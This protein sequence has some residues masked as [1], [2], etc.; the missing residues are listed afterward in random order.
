MKSRL[1]LALSLLLAQSVSG[2]TYQVYSPKFSHMAGTYSHG[3]SLELKTE[4]PSNRIFYTLNQATPDST[5]NLYTAPIPLDGDGQ[6]F[7]I[8][9]IAIDSLKKYSQVTSSYYEIDY[10][11]DSTSF[12]TGLS[13]EDYQTMLTGHWIGHSVTPWE[14]PYNIDLV[15]D[16]N[17]HFI[18][19]TLSTNVF[20]SGVEVFMPP[21]YYDTNM[22][23][24]GRIIAVK[25]ISSEGNGY[26]TIVI[27]QYDWSSWEAEMRSIRFSNHGQVLTL[28]MWNFDH[29]PLMFYLTRI[30][31]LSAEIAELGKDHLISIFPNP[32]KDIIHLNLQNPG[33][34][35]SIGIF[36]LDGINMKL[37][38]ASVKT[39]AIAVT[40]LAPGMY[41]LKVTFTDGH[42]S[43]SKFIKTADIR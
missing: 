5:S 19:Q 37:D 34:V 8:S 27:G 11:C 26:G 25:G 18:G 16:P 30:G 10:A 36:S 2:Q 40:D 31:T 42:I 29:G 3:L 12:M 4:H 14:S 24:P 20:P 39:G 35:K 15:I 9:A 1:Y 17:G 22:D 23:F 43:T 13:V 33:S 38:K 28:E 7:H 32:A 6:A 41:L 21:F